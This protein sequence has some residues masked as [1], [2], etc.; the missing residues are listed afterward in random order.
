MD[1]ECVICEECGGSGDVWE[2]IG[3]MYL[4]KYRIDDLAH[5]ITCPICDGEGVLEYCWECRL[6]EDEYRQRE[7]D[8]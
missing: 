8:R 1:C 4:G 5:M 7:Y 2:S 6:K 3:G